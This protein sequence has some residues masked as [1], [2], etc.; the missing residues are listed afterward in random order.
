MPFSA[1]SAAPRVELFWQDVRRGI[2]SLGSRRLRPIASHRLA[3][4]DFCSWRGLLVL[5]GAR[6]D[7]EPDGH[8]FRANDGQVALWFGAVDDL[9]KLG[10]PQGDGGPWH[11]TPVEAG[12]P[13][14]PSLMTGFDRKTLFLSHNAQEPVQMRLEIDYSNR[15]F[16]KTYGAIT[17]PVGETVTVQ[18]PDAYSA[19]WC[20][21]V[22]DRDCRATA[23]FEYR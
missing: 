20:R 22:A 15:D 19:H 5:A 23:R 7:A 13:S 16:W 9:W 8:I 3:I 14:D 11:Q 18:F 1:R 6:L 17:V 2:T 10:K 4:H 12:V 21:I